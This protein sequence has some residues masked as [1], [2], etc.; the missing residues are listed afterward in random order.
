[1]QKYL[2][3]IRLKLNLAGLYI[4]F[5]D[6]A[7]CETLLEE[8]KRHLIELQGISNKL[9]DYTHFDFS[10]TNLETNLRMMNIV[11]K[12]NYAIL[13]E[14]KGKHSE[15][16]QNHKD[17]LQI[18]PKLHESAFRLDYLKYLHRGEYHDSFVKLIEK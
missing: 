11:L 8:C 4:K 14:L 6:E 17:I 12:Q 5:D 1:M 3:F 10:N 9:K 18:C 13:N 15:A 16:I 2:N 7:I